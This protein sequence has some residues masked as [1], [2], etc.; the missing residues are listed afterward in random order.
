MDSENNSID[1]R[2][3]NGLAT[4]GSNFSVVYAASRSLASLHKT[5]SSLSGGELPAWEDY[6]DNKAEGISRF[7]G[8]AYAG[9]KAIS[10][11]AGRT[12]DAALAIA[13]VHEESVEKT[14]LTLRRSPSYTTIESNL[15]KPT[16]QGEQGIK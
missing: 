6:V 9:A 2:I 12:K 10:K 8:G 5:I 16:K 11:V 3:E 7:A 14:G 1:R 13:Q 15:L 4:F